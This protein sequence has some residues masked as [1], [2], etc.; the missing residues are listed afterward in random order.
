MWADFYGRKSS[1]DEGR[2]VASQEK[3]YL[4]DC[5]EQ[6]LEVGRKFSDPERS[7]SRYATR[8]RPDYAELLAHIR[9]GQCEL[10]CLWESSRGSRDLGEWVT[11]LDLCRKQGVLIRVISHARTYDVR[12]RRDWRTLADDGVDSDDESQKISERTTRGKRDAAAEGRPVGRRGFGWVRVYDQHGKV[13]TQ[14][15]DP[16]TGPVAAEIITRIAAGELAGRVAD[17]L[18]A[19]G[20]SAAEGGVWT[21][22]QVRQVAIN[23][24][25]GGFR[26]HRG[27]VTGKGTWEPLVDIAVWERARARMTAHPTTGTSHV[28]HWLSGA[29]TC[30]LCG[31][32]LRSSPRKIGD[33]YQCRDCFKV[34]ASA[35]GLEPVVEEHIL[36]RLR[37]ADA[38]ALFVPAADD[39]EVRAAM[40]AEQTLRDRLDALADDLGLPE[41]VL[42]R[43]AALL[44]AE[45]VA[46]TR[47]VQRLA[48][49]PELSDLA[50]VDVVAEWS[51]FPAATR[52]GI[53]RRIADIRLMPGTRYDGPRFNM[54]RLGSSRWVGDPMTWAEHW[55]LG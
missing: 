23:P 20:V 5:E 28:S 16:K 43:R 46:A 30:G 25:Y 2:S 35:R 29:I 26:V 10:L 1:K 38:A 40:D 33:A 54:L 3:D 44:Q 49:P 21:D 50:G 48:L 22:R 17:D 27:Q 4:A 45:L 37:R 36:G 19:R 9:A 31:G 7:A 32:N 55:A 18:N 8:T 41:R 15:P 42:A 11:F 6:G 47:K 13:T 52:R 53:T 51:N 12:V 34:S 24:T 14:T 39:S